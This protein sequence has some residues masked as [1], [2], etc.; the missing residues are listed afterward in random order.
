[1]ASGWLFPHFDWLPVSKLTQRRSNSSQ[2]QTGAGLGGQSFETE[3]VG[4]EKEIA[5]RRAGGVEDS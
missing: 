1:M 2:R 5:S 3:I 4:E